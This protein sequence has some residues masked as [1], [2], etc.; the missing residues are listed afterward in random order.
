MKHVYSRQFANCISDG[1]LF[2]WLQKHVSTWVRRKL[3]KK[4]WK[5]SVSFPACYHVLYVIL[6]LLLVLEYLSS[7]SA[8]LF[9]TFFFKSKSGLHF[10]PDQVWNR[11]APGLASQFDSP[12]TVPTIFPRPLLIVNGNKYSRNQIIKML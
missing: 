12:Y 11:I 10:F 9:F 2:F 5:R 1:L 6:V 8:P 7:S 3:T 4:Q